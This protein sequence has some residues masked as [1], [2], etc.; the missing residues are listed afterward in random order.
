MI[1]Q[2]WK[3]GPTSR[4]VLTYTQ[5]VSTNSEP[6]DN[7]DDSVFDD[8]VI[9]ESFLAGAPREESADERVARMRRIAQE[10]DRLRQAGEIADGAGKP[11][12]SR[13][14]RTVSWILIGS[15]AGGAIITAAL[16]VR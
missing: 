6:R 7:F 8:L 11:R 12:Y 10:N 14:A 15:L 5:E 4:T 2:P 9:D 13:T 16:L 3:L 1:G